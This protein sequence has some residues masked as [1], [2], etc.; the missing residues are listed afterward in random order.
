M[1][2][3]FNHDPGCGHCQHFSPTF[4]DIS[5]DLRDLILTA[6]INCERFQNLCAHESVR[7]YPTVRFYPGGNDGYGEEVPN[8]AP[9]YIVGFVHDR[10]ER[11]ARQTGIR[12]D[13]L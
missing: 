3:I 9:E 2:L 5:L 13:E 11:M 10:L 7:A 4:D 8:R 6:K 1:L 12:H